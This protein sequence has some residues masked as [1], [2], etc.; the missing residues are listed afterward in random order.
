MPE[1]G[2]PD[3]TL[4][5]NEDNHR[6]GPSDALPSPPTAFVIPECHI[7][8]RGFSVLTSVQGSHEDNDGNEPSSHRSLPAFHVVP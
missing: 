2:A 7:L 3:A 4:G 8:T 5:T 1:N 6:P